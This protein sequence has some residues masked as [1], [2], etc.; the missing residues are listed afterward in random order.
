[1][2]VPPPKDALDE[3]HQYR[4]ASWFSS[5]KQTENDGMTKTVTPLTRGYLADRGNSV[6]DAYMVVYRPELTWR[7][8]GYA[9]ALGLQIKHIEAVIHCSYSGLLVVWR[10]KAVTDVQ[11]WQRGRTTPRNR[12]YCTAHFQRR[13]WVVPVTNS[14]KPPTFN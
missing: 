10:T 14:A 3:L 1:M 12:V 13:L 8:I 5:T 11:S 9:E 4:A 7:V 2:T 6:T